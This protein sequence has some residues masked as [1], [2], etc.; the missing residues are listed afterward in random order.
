MF[1]VYQEWKQTKTTHQLSC[2]CIGPFY[3]TS[4]R[5]DAGMDQPLRNEGSV[6]RHSEMLSSEAVPTD[7]NCDANQDEWRRETKCD[8]ERIPVTHIERHQIASNE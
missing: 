4:L 3:I 6:I 2:F 8:E 1:G 5:I 7:Q